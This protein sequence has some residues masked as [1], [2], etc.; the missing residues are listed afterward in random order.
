MVMTN[1]TF[2]IQLNTSYSPGIIVLFSFTFIIIQ[3]GKKIILITI[4]G[5]KFIN[6]IFLKNVL[7][8]SFKEFSYKCMGNIL[9]PS[10]YFLK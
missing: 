5:N 1:L 10:F 2:I 3:K 9:F 8:K 4:I 7:I 6:R